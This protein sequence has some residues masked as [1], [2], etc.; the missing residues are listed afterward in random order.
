MRRRSR[1]RRQPTSPRP[2]VVVAIAVALLAWFGLP[3]LLQ[4][5]FPKAPPGMV[6]LDDPAH[7]DGRFWI[8][9][10]EFPNTSGQLPA[11]Y[12]SAQQAADACHQQGKR[13]C[14][15]AEWRRACLGPGGDL[16][17]GY[18]TTY[19]RGRCHT[20][21]RLPSGHTSLMEP[22]E[23][24]VAAGARPDCTT[25]EGVHDLIGNLEEWVLDAAPGGVR[26]EGGAWYTYALYADCTGRYSRAP[27]YRLSP[28]RA[29]YSAGFRCCWSDSIPTE[30][31]IAAD[32]L[33]TLTQAAEADSKAS[34]DPSDEVQI[35]AGVWMDRYEYPNRK[36]ELPR[37]VIDWTEADAACTAAGK[38]LCSTREWESACAGAHDFRYPYGQR[39]VEGG[40]AVAES[41]PLPS[42][43]RSACK[44]TVGVTDLVGSVWEWTADII[45]APVLYSGEGPPLHELR[46]G[47]WFSD[48][49]KAVC[50]PVDGYPAAPADERYPRVGF[51]CCRGEVETASVA[52]I[53]PAVSCPDDMVA[54][55]DFCID[56]GEHP[57]LIGQMPQG[58]Y[59][60][61]TAKAACA[62][63][64]RQLCTRSQWMRACAGDDG[65]RWPYGDTFD[66]G[67]CNDR[68]AATHEV[69]GGWSAT[70]AHPDCTSPEGVLDLSG[71]YWEWVR[72][73]GSDSRGGLLGGGWNLSAG[74]N[75][76]RA[77][78]NARLDHADTQFGA[79]CCLPGAPL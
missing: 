19:A 63:R 65:R 71:N 52:P 72:E 51:R 37:V 56:R 13:L 60:F 66:K 74:L 41:G 78:A 28:D 22:C 31:D 20:E 61:A 58:G 39:F 21:G 42:G 8:D 44:N 57:N 76:C 55:G 38:R 1:R 3:P 25:P 62:Q 40:C 23:L 34:Y 33:R 16:R 2:W 26:L 43:S 7:T 48:A 64:G 35:S 17:F 9:A 47:S 49:S 69:G 4:Q 54:V 70:G 45:D 67:A 36:G 18:G 59:S 53:P 46:G 6:A 30:A 68:S 29:V 11:H 75:Q 5:V 10:Y 73:D 77:E 14:T 12:T 32:Q 79:R 50:R 15:A 24:L 27:D